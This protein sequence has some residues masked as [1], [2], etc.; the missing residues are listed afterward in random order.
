MSVR[1]AALVVALSFT[2]AAFADEAQVKR[3]VEARFAGMKVTSV[4]KTPYSGLYEVVVGDT[5]F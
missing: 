2:A 3:G 1:L 4:A 5:I